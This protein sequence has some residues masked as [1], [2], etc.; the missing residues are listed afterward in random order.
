MTKKTFLTSGKLV[1]TI[2]KQD[3]KG[4]YK[5]C[6]DFYDEIIKYPQFDE[7]KL[8]LKFDE[9]YESINSEWLEEEKDKMQQCVEIMLEALRDIEKVDPDTFAVIAKNLSTSSRRAE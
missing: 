5:V 6:Y 4:Q 2:C 1:V 9:I 7:N 8:C 3:Y